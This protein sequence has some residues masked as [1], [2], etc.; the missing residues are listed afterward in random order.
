M[1]PCRVILSLV[2]FSPAIA[3]EIQ[4]PGD[5]SAST[6]NTT[7]RSFS[8]TTPIPAEVVTI[9]LNATDTDSHI[10]AVHQFLTT[11]A[12]V[13]E[14]PKNSS[15]DLG[16]RS[17]LPRRYSGCR[18]P[19]RETGS[20][21]PVRQCPGIYRIRDA[22]YLRS[23]L[24]GYEN[25]LPLVC[26]PYRWTSEYFYSGQRATTTRAPRYNNNNDNGYGSYQNPYQYGQQDNY[27]RYYPQPSSRYPQY[28]EYARPVNNLYFSPTS[29]RPSRTTTTVT[30][31]ATTR[32]P[33]T[34]KP[35]NQEVS[36]TRPRKPSFLPEKC[37]LGAGLRRIVGG[38]EARVGDYPWMAAIYYNQQNSWLQACGGALVS[39]L[40]VVTAA[41][42]VVAGSRSQNL[43]TRYF[44]VRLGDHDLVSEDD[45]SASEDFK[46]AKIS[47]HS[48]FN[49]ETYKNDIALMQL[50]TPVTFNEFIGPLCLPYDGVYGNLDNEIA[51]VSGWGYTKYEGKGSNVLKQ[52]AIRIWP[53]NECREAYKKEVDITPEYLCAGDGKQD[54]CQGDSGGPLFYNE[55]TKFYL[56]GVVSFGKKC[57]TPGYPGAYTRVTKYL[58]WLNDHF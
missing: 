8:S 38:T 12:S 48:Q 34:R 20:C 11:P 32:T 58:D 37:G 44:L 35:S 19:T 47:R 41:H 55:G 36:S 2:L 56:I 30:P 42:C 6:A 50:E 29:Q 52:A 31:R 1:W 26:C 22:S 49:S 4:F 46:V 17:I 53:E 45:S 16:G 14:D 3:L 57:A 13:E 54:S 24:C 25:Q 40:H 21:G 10:E 39:N 51:I 33:A 7:P 23:F 28:P 15:S 27:N 18:A 5:D 9:A 43:P